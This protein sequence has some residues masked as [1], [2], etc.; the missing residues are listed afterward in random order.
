MNKG[1]FDSSISIC[2]RCTHQ[3]GFIYKWYPDG[4]FEGRFEDCEC[5]CMK[6]VLTNLEFLEWE[7]EQTISK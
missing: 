4:S 1:F 2:R 6:P 7:Y 5:K 3:H